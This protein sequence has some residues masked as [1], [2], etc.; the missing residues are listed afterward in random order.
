MYLSRNKKVK[1]FPI[2]FSSPAENAYSSKINGWAAIEYIDF[3]I[4]GNKI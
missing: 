1:R 3:E 2:R 4:T